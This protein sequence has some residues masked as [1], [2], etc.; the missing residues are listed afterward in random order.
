MSNL[1]D[2]VENP[3]VVSD[4]LGEWPGFH[5]AEILSIF[6]ERKGDPSATLVVQAIPYSPDRKLPESLITVKFEGLASLDLLNFNHQNVI[7]V[8]DIT[9]DG[10]EK[11]LKIR[12]LNGAEVSFTFKRATVL[13]VE[14]LSEAED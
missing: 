5:D 4:V 6:L 9:V 14:R 12:A 3:A 8:L 13:E 2:H 11:H 10:D 7:G 1:E